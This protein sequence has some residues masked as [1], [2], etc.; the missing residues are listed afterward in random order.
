M[1]VIRR[2]QLQRLGYLSREQFVDEMTGHVYRYFPDLAWSLTLDELRNCLG[3]TIRRADAYGFTSRQQLCRFI[4]LAATYGWEFDTDADLEWMR[5]ILTDGALTNP[6]ERLNRL[7]DVCMH[8]QRIEE[9]NQQLRQQLGLA[10]SAAAS[11]PALETSSDYAGQRQYVTTQTSA[12]I[13]E[14]IVARNPLAYHRSHSLW[15]SPEAAST[16]H[17]ARD[18]RADDVSAAATSNRR[19]AWP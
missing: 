3:T 1:L 2:P 18:A 5:T 16:T 4:N 13:T 12:A 7:I 9:H 15:F 17:Q 10:H 11:A 19:G 8:R 6:S 14:E